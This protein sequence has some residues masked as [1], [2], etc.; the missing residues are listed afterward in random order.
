MIR[1]HDRA[2]RRHQPLRI[3]C[4]LK[5]GFV[6][7]AATRGRS[8]FPPRQSMD[9]LPGFIRPQDQARHIAADVGNPCC[10]AN[11]RAV[12][13]HPSAERLWDGNDRKQAL[14]PSLALSSF[15][16]LFSSS[17]PQEAV[18]LQVVAPTRQRQAARR[19]GDQSLSGR[20]RVEVSVCQP[21]PRS[22]PSAGV[23][24]VAWLRFGFA[25][26]GPGRPLADSASGV[27]I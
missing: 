16:R 1:G 12:V 27:E 21:Q 8:V 14:C 20:S 22:P 7:S 19:P 10:P 17:S 26:E 13:G 2:M 6:H 3:P 4:G 23:S 25:F 24:H 15:W 9:A 18:T 5:D 11:Q